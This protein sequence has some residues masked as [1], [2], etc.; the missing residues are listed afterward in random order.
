[1]LAPAN[2]YGHL[3]SRLAREATARQG[4]ALGPISFYSP[5]AGAEE[6]Q[7]VV[8]GMAQS[9][10]FDALLIPDGGLRLLQLLPQL[11]VQELTAPK[12]QLLG[13]G[14]WADPRVQTEPALRGAWYVSPQPEGVSSF[15]ERFRAAY[16]YEPGRIAPLGYDATALAILLSQQPS[17]AD[18]SATALSDR[19]GFF[20]TEGIFRFGAGGTAERGLAV[21][22]IGGGGQLTVASQ[23]PERFPSPATAGTG[24]SA[25][26]ESEAPASSE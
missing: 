3:V 16:G 26:P 15:R 1:V 13:T 18:F 19:R 10:G 7:Q 23:A 4:V 24:T 25:P 20:G 11:A 12:V 14:L 21:I 17:G 8:R 6:L 9:G 2:G 5:D 22:E